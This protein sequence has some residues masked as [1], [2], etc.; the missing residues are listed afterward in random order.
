MASSSPKTS[1]DRLTN[2]KR[3]GAWQVRL[4]AAAPVVLLAAHCLVLLC[5]SRTKSVTAD[6]Q[7]HLLAGYS[8]LALRDYG[9][10]QQHHHPALGTM[11]NA[12]PLLFVKDL[13]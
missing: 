6:E 9:Y 11:L 7:L 3:L 2:A 1:V 12:V 5:S 10:S 4:L 13:K 8:S